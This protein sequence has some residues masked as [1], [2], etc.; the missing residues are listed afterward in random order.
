VILHAIERRAAERLTMSRL[1]DEMNQVSAILEKGRDLLQI[2]ADPS[3][4]EAV[5][6]MVEAN[7]GS[8]LVTEGGEI[9]GIVTEGDYL[10]RVTREGRT[11]K[12][13]AVR[14]IIRDSPD[15]QGAR[16]CSPRSSGLSALA[17]S[18]R[19]AHYRPALA[20][21]AVRPLQVMVSSAWPGRVQAGSG[22]DPRPRHVRRGCIAA[23]VGPTGCKY[24]SARRRIGHAPNER[25]T[26]PTWLWIVIIV[27]VVVAILGYFGRGR[28]SR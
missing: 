10:R 3:V 4:F 24:R 16:P 15:G 27:V 13:T 6:R 1:R 22:A 28:L 26:V 8:L 5:K 19:R 9:N 18:K 14:E 21:R 2:E 17:Q 23:R 12:A 25:I 20:R 11:D 7:V